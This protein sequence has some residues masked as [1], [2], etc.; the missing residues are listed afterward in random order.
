MRRIPLTAIQE[1]L[2][3]FLREAKKESIVILKRGKPAGMLV[4]FAGKDEYLEYLLENNPAFLDRVAKARKDL[5][6]GRGIRL[7]DVK[8]SANRQDRKNAR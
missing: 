6:L 2:A 5:R 3:H 7:E 1:N 8:G 4:G